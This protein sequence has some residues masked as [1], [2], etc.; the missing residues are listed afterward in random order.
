VNAFIMFSASVVASGSV[1]TTLGPLSNASS[2]TGRVSGS[3]A[4][5]FSS[6]STVTGEQS[7]PVAWKAIVCLT[8]AP[9]GR[10]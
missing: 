3:G 9:F 2:A 4:S 1:S 10:W 7:K 6:T 8:A 5:P